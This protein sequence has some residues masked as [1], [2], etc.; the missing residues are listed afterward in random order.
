MPRTNHLRRARF[1]G[2]Y[3]SLWAQRS[4]EDM[5]IDGIL[6]NLDGTLI[7]STVLAGLRDE[8]RWQECIVNINRTRCFPYMD[9]VLSRLRDK[10]IRIGIVTS[11]ITLYA[12]RA[13]RHHHIA[14]DALIAYHD[15]RPHKPYP[16][17]ITACLRK[18]S[19]RADR[20]IGVGDTANDCA[21]Y[22]AAGV[23]SAGAGWSEHLADDVN[24][25][26]VLNTPP[27]LLDYLYG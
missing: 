20:A 7:E 27:E 6:F 21:A 19:I 5:L 3:L 1:N 2:I 23:T 13:L 11:S 4:C 16:A 10:G 8:G 9:R 12:E 26:L 14:Y 22:G 15:V 18:L 24:W 25:D 17:P